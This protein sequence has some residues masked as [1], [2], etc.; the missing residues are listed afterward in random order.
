MQQRPLLIE[1]NVIR[2]NGDEGIALR[3]GLQAIPILNPTTAQLT[4][5]IRNNT[6]ANNGQNGVQVQTRGSTTAR[7]AIDNNTINTNGLRG[8]DLSTASLV[9]LGPLNLSANIR[10]NTFTQGANPPVVQAQTTSSPLVSQTLCFNLTGNTFTNISNVSVVN[11]LNVPVH[12]LIWVGGIG[13][14]FTLNTFPVFSSAS[15]SGTITDLPA[16]P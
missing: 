2:N 5:I 9:G 8:V 12:T 7:V 14:V 15:T 13:Q 16:C 6:I 1:N 3:L 4:G 10:Q 11:P